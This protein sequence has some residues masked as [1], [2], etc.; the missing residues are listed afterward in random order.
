MSVATEFSESF[1]FI[2]ICAGLKQIS[3]EYKF[4]SDYGLYVTGVVD[5]IQD[6]VPFTTDN[7]GNFTLFKSPYPPTTNLTSTIGRFQYR[8]SPTTFLQYGYLKINTAGEIYTMLSPN[9][10]YYIPQNQVDISIR[11]VVMENLQYTLTIP[12]AWARI[13]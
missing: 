5:V 7:S 11:Y 4:N 2:D 12:Y 3:A 13:S 10:T 1:N 9:T 8:N 6:N